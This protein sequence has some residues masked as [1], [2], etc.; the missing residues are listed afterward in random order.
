MTATP[1]PTG[2][3]SPEGITSISAILARILW[4]LLGP[5]AMGLVAVAIV[6][7]GNGWLTPLDAFY[8]VV[9]ALMIGGRWVEQRSG[10]AATVTGVPATIEH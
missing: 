6:T 8:A 2:E 9:V 5:A 10:T 1:Q 7:C 3:R 4:T